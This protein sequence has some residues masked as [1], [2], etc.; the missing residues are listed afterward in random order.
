MV[1]R[2]GRSCSLVVVVVM[3]MGVPREADDIPYRHLCR[4][5]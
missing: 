1:G 3:V 4:G 5:T 2:R